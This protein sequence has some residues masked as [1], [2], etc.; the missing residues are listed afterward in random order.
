MKKLLSFALALALLL[1][2]SAC[3]RF[4]KIKDDDMTAT[5]DALAATAT[6]INAAPAPMEP[7]Q[8]G[9]MLYSFYGSEPYTTRI[10]EES[11]EEYPVYPLGLVDRDGKLVSPPVYHN[12][13]YIYDEAG[14]RVIGLT[15]VKDREI[16]IYELDGKHGK[17]PC[18]G[19]RIEVYP[20]GRYAAV[21]TAPDMQWHGGESA[22]DHMREGLYDIRNGKYLVEPK[23]GQ[24]LNYK[25]GGVVLGYQYSADNISDGEQTA[26]WAYRL[27]DKSRMELPMSLG[28]V[29]DYY[30]E[31]G[32][33][34]AMHMEGD[35]EQRVYDK[36]L[37]VIP[38]LTG[39]SV[40]Y[41][42]F[43]GGQWCMIYNNKALPGVHTWVDR[44]GNLSDK[45]YKD[46]YSSDGWQCYFSGD[47]F[48]WIKKTGVLFDTDLNEVCRTDSG[49]RLA[50]LR[51]L[52]GTDQYFA[53]LDAGKNIKAVYDLAAKPV[54]RA[55]EQFRCLLDSDT[56]VLFR[57]YEGEWRVLDLKQFFPRHKPEHRG[58]EAYANAVA[59][60]GD[61]VVVG[62]G[63]HWYE[64]GAPYEIFAV[65]WDGNRLDSCPLEPFFDALGYQNA[66]EQ[67]PYYY[68]VELE[69]KRGYINT[70]GEWLFVE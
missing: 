42:G 69:G 62:T 26:Q 7:L 55:P 40:D 45:R 17:L 68:W 4:T 18:E 35:W 32:W 5:A 16:Y 70:Q 52:D 37:K 67:G 2:L 43:N 27:E 9:P 13:Q 51:T 63:V 34:G 50:V 64:A 12:V 22:E 41:A 60:C 54:A 24:M 6:D 47:N 14:R 48:D 44:A 36:D 49:E 28:R 66:G 3:N 46:I 38:A 65:D 19:Y 59:A 8:G 31:T 56:G 11:G 25:Q 15:A 58:G 61:F 20:G 1:S 21:Y 23:D 29:Q 10:G 57:G 30:P 33:F 53:L 39:W